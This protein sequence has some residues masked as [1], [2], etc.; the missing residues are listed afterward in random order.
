MKIIYDFVGDFYTPFITVLSLLVLAF[1]IRTTVVLS[2]QNWLRTY[3]HTITMILL[4]VITYTITTVIAGNIA[5]SLG[6]V[7][8]LS[9][10]RFRNPVKSPYELA[11]YFLFITLGVAASVNLNWMWFLAGTSIF[12]IV[13]VKFVD[14]V[15][16]KIKKNHLFE[17][18]FSEGNALHVLEVTIDQ[19]IEVLTQHPRLIAMVLEPSSTHYRFADADAENLLALMRHLHATYPSVRLSYLAP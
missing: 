11:L 15:Y 17:V 8:A 19:P 9:I 4:P 5:L 10:V 2:G 6:M 18:S 7:G 14:Y 1:L 3:S 13:F 12:V 16:L